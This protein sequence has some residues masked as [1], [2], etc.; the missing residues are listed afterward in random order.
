MLKSK[1]QS[2]EPDAKQEAQFQALYTVRNVA[3]KKKYTNKTKH[4]A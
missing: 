3:K 1:I 4:I 2:P